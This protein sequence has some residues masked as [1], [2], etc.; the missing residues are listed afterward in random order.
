MIYSLLLL[1]Q[2]WIH[3]HKKKVEYMNLE[4]WIYVILKYILKRKKNKL[5]HP[6]YN[7]FYLFWIL[8]FNIF[9]HY[10]NIWIFHLLWQI[11]LFDVSLKLNW[12]PNN[13]FVNL[14]QRAL[15]VA[16]DYQLPFFNNI[17]FTSALTHFFQYNHPLHAI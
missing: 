11:S 16:W 8:E 7:I 6:W 3:P 12:I 4:R 15:F 1:V 17:S 5:Y 2:I 14:G 13:Q 9:F 10:I